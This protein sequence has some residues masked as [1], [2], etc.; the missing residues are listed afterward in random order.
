MKPCV[1]CDGDGYIETFN[2]DQSDVI[3]NLCSSC[4]GTGVENAGIV[5]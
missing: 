2:D 4:N 5:I 1:I 3:I